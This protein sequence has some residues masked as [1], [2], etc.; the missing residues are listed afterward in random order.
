MNPV[1][2]ETSMF[3]PCSRWG[4][5]VYGGRGKLKGAR[6]LLKLSLIIYKIE[7][8]LSIIIHITC[9]REAQTFLTKGLGGHVSSLSV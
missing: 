7:F 5:C 9:T 8:I 6:S 1:P 4:T 2:L 3:V